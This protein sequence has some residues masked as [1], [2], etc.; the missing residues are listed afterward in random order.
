[1]DNNKK[2]NYNSNVTKED[3]QA[4]KERPDL[5]NR[6]DKTDFTG[7]NLDI[8]GRKLPKEKN[9]KTLKDEE[10]TIYAKGSSSNENLERS[11]DI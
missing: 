8:P 10:N 4:L 5:K 1:M 7:K 9:N 2:P 6:K 11:E 3:V